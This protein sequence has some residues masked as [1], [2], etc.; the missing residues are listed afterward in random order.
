MKVASLS[1]ENGRGRGRRPS[2]TGK[3]Q[4][5]KQAVAVGG[6]FSG[7][8]GGRRRKV[9]GRARPQAEPG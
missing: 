2:R 9:A 4:V 5:A 8:V 1:V 7:L 3:I 6:R